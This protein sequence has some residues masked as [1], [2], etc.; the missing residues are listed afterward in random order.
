MDAA[1]QKSIDNLNAQ[2]AAE[3]KADAAVVALLEGLAAQIKT[4]GS[5]VTDPA[6]LAAIDAAAAIVKTNADAS[7]AAVVANTPAA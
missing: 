6:V 7:A 4:L 5:G 1:T 2:V 3:T